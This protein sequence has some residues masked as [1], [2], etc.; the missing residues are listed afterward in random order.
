MTPTTAWDRSHL[1]LLQDDPAT[2]APVIKP[3]EV[4]PVL[5]GYYLWDP[6]PLRLP[7]GELAHAGGTEIWMALSAPAWRPPGERH[8][9]ARIRILARVDG[10]WTDLGP[11]FAEGKSA[12]SREW[13]GCARLDPGSGEVTVCYTATG[14]RGEDVYTYA[15]RLFT[16]RARLETVPSVRLVDWSGHEEMVRPGDHYQSTVMQFTGKPGFIKA[17]RDPFLFVDPARGEDVLLFTASR[18]N[19]DTSFDGAVGI[20]RRTEDRGWEPLPPL[21]HADGVNN[22]LERP[23][24]VFREGHYYLFF[25]TQART[26]HPEVSGP[27]GLY[28]FVSP[29]L[30]GPWNPLN[31]SGLVLRNP[32]EQPFQAY[33]WLVLNDLSVISFVDHHSLGGRHPDE[34]ERAGEGSEHFGGTMAPTLHITLSGDRARLEAP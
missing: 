5:P 14:N 15:Q 1:A 18:Q 12:G 29:S 8:D 9:V 13:A 31:G 2:Y 22:E 33:S 6:W 28:G 7:G 26:F 24:L 20:A 17:F 21:I 10:R 16:A 4:V 25:S 34:V 27:T 32:P 23:H 19:S 11:A 3:E 30:Q